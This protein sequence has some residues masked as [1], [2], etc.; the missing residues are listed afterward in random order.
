[1]VN[2]IERRASE[3]VSGSQLGRLRALARRALAEFGVTAARLTLLRHEQ[4]TTF[5]VDVAG[6][7]YV[8]RIS[9]PG[10]SS[11]ESVTSEMA[12]LAALRRDTDLSVPEPVAARDG[13]LVV[14]ASHPGVTEPRSC[15]LLR[16]MD[17]R[18]A[19]ASLR[20]RHLG[21]VGELIATLHDHAEGWQRPPG[22]VRQRVDTLTSPAKLASIGDAAAVVGSGVPD[23]QDIED[24]KRLITD[25]MP[26][27]A[28][29]IV[30]D[31]LDVVVASTRQLARRP[32]SVG[33]IH[34]DLHNENYLFRADK[35][36]A[37]DFDDCGWGFL[38]YDL[39]EALWE[40]E[41]RP[42]YPRLRDALLGEYSRRRTLPDDADAHLRALAILRR[43]QMLM[44]VLESREHEAF[45][46]DWRQWAA[47]ELRGIEAAVARA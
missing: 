26:V 10:T 34:S 14:V 15:V 5:R 36:I 6:E 4:N 29:S 46:D 35:V 43:V 21:L 2:N 12:W 32:G 24:A 18:F 31:A 30:V 13:A 3:V 45:R 20:P 7:R 47:K 22:F 40:L 33:L 8:L 37:I 19:D 44:W 42:T 17:G 11:P 23:G 28:G 9:R 39:S 25:L 41:S 27:R 16:W 1:M 38:L